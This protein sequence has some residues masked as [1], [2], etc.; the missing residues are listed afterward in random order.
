MGG[1]NAA[2][3]Q[4]EFQ[5]YFLGT[6]VININGVPHLEAYL[7]QIAGKTPGKGTHYA[8]RVNLG[9]YDT[10][11]V[12]AFFTDATRTQLITG[13]RSIV[14]TVEAEQILQKQIGNT[15]TVLIE[16]DHRIP[17]AD[18]RIASDEKTAA[19]Q[20]AIDLVNFSNDYDAITD[21]LR[22]HKAMSTDLKTALAAYPGLEDTTI[23]ASPIPKGGSL[24]SGNV[25]LSKL[26]YVMDIKV[27]SLPESVL[28]QPSQLPVTVTSEDYWKNSFVLAPG[29]YTVAYTA[30]GTCDFDPSVSI[31]GS[32]SIPVVQR[33]VNSEQVSG[34]VSITVPKLGRSTIYAG[35]SGCDWS[36]TI[37]QP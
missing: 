31:V 28:F 12:V 21:P 13:P 14:N 2:N 10:T 24:D 30:S 22:F 20:T 33:S 6:Q 25:D 3:W 16:A 9:P 18:P 1:I 37:S 11:H 34:S 29:T 32:V 27:T 26:P 35:S 23:V 17:A 8:I 7:G 4:G 36:V 15:G 19:D 5:V